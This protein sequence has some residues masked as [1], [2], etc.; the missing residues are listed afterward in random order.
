MCTLSHVADG[1]PWS[2][3]ELAR[4]A[5]TTVRNVRLY[6]ER[7]LLPPPERRGRVGL[8]GPS[9]LDRLR[10]VLALIARGYPMAAIREL[11]EAWSERR[12]LGEVLGFEEA[13]AQPFTD[14]QPRTFSL[15]ELAALFPDADEDAVERAVASGVLVPAEDGFVAP[16]PALLEV[17]R[18]LMA[19][20][21]PL[22]AVLDVAA[23][24]TTASDRLA[25]AFV[26]L[27]QDHVWE[28]FVEADEPA[29]RWPEVTAA[30]NRQRDLWARAVMPALGV[31]MQRRVDETRREVVNRELDEASPGESA[32]S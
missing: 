12:T 10:L 18:E 9:H 11:L 20:G 15:D 13:L 31:A 28:P 4:L 6:Q 2:I 5:G 7:G 25:A 19:D 16:V 3:D 14:E 29:E 23:E 30:L 21:V 27:F 32:A 17:G 8:Y 1:G 22:P 24:I 26:A